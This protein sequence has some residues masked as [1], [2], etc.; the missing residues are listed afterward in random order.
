MRKKERAKKGDDKKEQMR[1]NREN[2][3]PLERNASAHDSI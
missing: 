3:K 2:S 1:D